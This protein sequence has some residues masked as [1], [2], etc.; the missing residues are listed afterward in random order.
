LLGL[1]RLFAAN[2]PRVCLTITA[3][4]AE[5]LQHS[6]YEFE[7][8]YRKLAA[9]MPRV[10]NLFTVSL[11]Q[12]CHEFAANLPQICCNIAACFL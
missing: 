10:Y 3:H 1:C 7:Y 5:Y 12:V 6:Y 8:V 9:N 2:L 4:I 11:M